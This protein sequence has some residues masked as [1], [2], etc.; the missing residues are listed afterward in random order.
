MQYITQQIETNKIKPG[1]KFPSIVNLSQLFNCSK[2]TIIKAYSEFEKDHLIYSI[3][4]SG[5]YLVDSNIHGKKQLQSKVIDFSSASPDI[6]ILPYRDFQHCLNTAIDMYKENLFSYGSPQGLDTLI[7]T[8]CKQFANFQIFTN[9]ENIFITTGSQQA[10]N[11]LS[12]IAFPNGKSNVL[13]EQPT[14]H[15]ILKSLMINNVKALG[16]MRTFS[17]INLD[18]LERLF[19]N[20]N[21]KF[22]YTVP[23]F[24]NP[25]G[26]SYSKYEKNQILKLAEKYDVYI[27]E[28]D[29]LSDLENNTKEDSMF[30]LDTNNR[31]IYIKSFS[32]TFLPGLRI[33]A[34]ILPSILINI[35][36]NYKKWSD[37]NT[38]IL[39]QGALEIYIKSGM[40]ENHRRK[41]VKL[42]SK[43]MEF[44]NNTII[45]FNSNLISFNVP[46]SGFF[47]SLSVNHKIDSSKIVNSLLQKNIL[48]EE[49][50]K[51]FLKEFSMDNMFRISISKADESCIKKGIPIIV[52]EILKSTN[53][54]IT[55][56]DFNL[57]I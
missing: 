46:R 17:G 12:A 51:F 5:Y 19:R 14:Y 53:S 1:D 6:N 27:V 26:L 2:S 47:A 45:S 38:P 30:A 34:V 57:D 48:L 23:R 56:N 39:S 24:N 44:L 37:L 32:K 50:S 31:V 4:K 54:K 43:R 22:F 40:F 21:I 13:V 15:G 7:N 36:V 10:I 11:I 8:L 9:T 25:L 42:Y 20:G 41:M 29:Y 3:P 16:I 49:C 33:G 52:E 35:F 55:F 28:D 18:E